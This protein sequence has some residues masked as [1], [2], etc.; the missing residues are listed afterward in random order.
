MLPSPP[1]DPVA[2]VRPPGPVAPVPPVL[3]AR[4]VAPV[5]PVLPMGPVAPVPPVGPGRKVLKLLTGQL[6]ILSGY[7]TFI[8]I[9]LALKYLPL[10][11]VC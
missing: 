11:N 6:N 4:P 9:F 8:T 7:C 3:P 10:I 1:G 2:P 5:P